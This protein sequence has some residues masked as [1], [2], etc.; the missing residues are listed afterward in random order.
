MDIPL[1]ADIDKQVSTAYG[2]KIDVGDAR[3]AAYRATYIIDGNGILRQY[4]ISDL[5]VGRSIPEV[6]F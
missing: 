1:L 6:I 2:C 4:S 5:P 3:G